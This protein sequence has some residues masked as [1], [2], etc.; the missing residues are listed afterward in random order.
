[1]SELG[2]KYIFVG[3]NNKD[4]IGGSCSIIEHKYDTRRPPTRIMFDLGALFAPDDCLD[5]DAIIPDVRKYLN[6]K[7]S[8]AEKKIDAIFLTHSHEDHI[9]GYVHLAR[10]GY[11]MPPTYASLGTLELLK[12]ALI[13]AGVEKENWPQM[14][15]VEAGKPV[16]FDGVEVEGFNVSHTTFDPMG[17]HTLTTIDGEDEAGIL[18]MGDYH[19]GKIRVGNGFDEN[20][21]KDLLQRKLVTNVILDSTS[22]SSDDR[23]LVTH[24]EAVNNTVKVVNQHSDKQVVSAVISRSIQ[25]LAID[26]D[27]AKRTGR[28]VFLD[29]YWAK[30]AFKAMQNCGIHEFDNVIFNRSASE[31]KENFKESERYIIT[32]GAFAESKKGRKSGLFKMS[33][34]EKIRKRKNK[35]EHNKDKE[36]K[37]MLGHPDFEI[38]YNTLILGRQRWIKDINGEQVIKMYGRLAGLGAVLVVNESDDAIGKYLTAKMQRS[39]HAVESEQENLM[40]II[41]EFAPN[42]KNIVY[43]AT[44]GNPTQLI[45]TAKIVKKEKR[46]YFF[47][48]NLDVLLMGKNETKKIDEIENKLWIGV[49]EEMDNTTRRQTYTYTLTDENFIVHKTLKSVERKLPNRKNKRLK[50]RLNNGKDR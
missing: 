39:G 17:F 7:D 40:Y 19:M 32:S 15:V 44:H 20:K 42:S 29:G 38:D 18:H 22:T 50:N 45:N 30:I 34:Q 3:G 21:F 5:V 33:E 48:V 12:S 24:E 10:A 43:V 35:K 16:N 23:Y 47:G 1:M 2:T 25:N 46:K 31:Y 26:L 41:D 49:C 11:Y 37:R 14:T 28:E 9:G 36:N 13:E 4:R 8:L 6:G 27:V